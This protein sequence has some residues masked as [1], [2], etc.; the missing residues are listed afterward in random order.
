MVSDVTF[1]GVRER[2]QDTIMD[3]HDNSVVAVI[4][5]H[6]AAFDEIIDAFQ[7]RLD[8][9]IAAAISKHQA[10]QAVAKEAVEASVP[11]KKEHEDRT[12]QSILEEEVGSNTNDGGE[13]QV[14]M[15]GEPQLP[16][17]AN[18][19]RQDT[20]C[21]MRDVYVDTGQRHGGQGE[22]RLLSLPVHD[23]QTEDGPAPLESLFQHAHA[24]RQVWQSP[25]F[26]K[27][28][29]A[30]LMITSERTHSAS[31]N[32]DHI[33]F[34]YIWFG[35]IPRPIRGVTLQYTWS[36]CMPVVAKRVELP[37]SV[38]SAFDFD[39][40][41]TYDEYDENYMLV[42]LSPNHMPQELNPSK[43]LAKVNRD[44]P[45]VFF[46]DQC[47]AVP[48]KTMHFDMVVGNKADL[49]SIQ[50][51]SP[52]LKI[53]L[54]H[55]TKM[56]GGQRDVPCGILCPTFQV[57]DAGQLCSTLGHDHQQ[58]SHVENITATRLVVKHRW[59]PDGLTKGN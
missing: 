35:D 9:M 53:L 22:A 29:L 42:R 52:Q 38:D 7:R 8:E 56:R 4:D 23:K 18:C 1:V 55:Q 43:A 13:P 36:P 30:N 51:A 26:L 20:D 3:W 16:V 47:M 40:E 44:Q 49:N 12:E 10:E 45:V 24:G 33:E 14:H 41:P 11:Q 25:P 21:P 31:P 6:L 32:H 37:T 28:H 50:S 5:K 57:V 39:T 46:P 34:N 27:V 59:P 2:K 54:G 17:M 19:S 15:G 48:D 58:Q